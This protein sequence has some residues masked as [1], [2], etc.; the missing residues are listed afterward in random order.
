M[1]IWST[2][3][4]I[5]SLFV[6]LRDLGVL[7][8]WFRLLLLLNADPYDFNSL[9]IYLLIFHLPEAHKNSFLPK[10]SITQGE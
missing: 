6:L 7:K 9:K 5:G 2:T 3:A 10:F 1:S 4:S 8:G